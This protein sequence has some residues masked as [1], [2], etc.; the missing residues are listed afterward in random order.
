[1][2]QAP[3]P[4]HSQPVPFWRR[5]GAIALYPL[6]GAAL[7]TLILLT[8]LGMLGWLPS[9]GWIFSI[10]VYFAGYKYAFEI[11]LR[12]ANGDD[13]PPE[14]SIEAQNGAVW[15]LLGVLLALS[16][17]VKL[18]F[19]AG[20]PAAGVLALAL[21]T[22]IQPA[23][24]ALLATGDGLFTAL[25]PA[26]AVRMIDRIGA[27]YFV[28][29]AA[30]LLIQ[31]AV[32]LA[33]ASLASN[34]PGF[35]AS[36]WIDAL[37]FWGLFASFHLLGLAM[38]QYHDALGYTP[39]RHANALPTP[40]D[41]DRALLDQ[42]SIHASHGDPAGA[43]ALLR[44]ELRERPLA[45]AV[46]ERYRQLLREAGDSEAL[47][48][49]A[50]LY[51]AMLAQSKQDRL[52]LGAL[53]EALDANPHFSRLDPELRE[54]LVRRALELGQSRLAV[55]AMQALLRADPRHPDATGWALQAAQ[56]LQDRFGESTAALSVLQT[57][58]ATCRNEAGIAELDAAIARLQPVEPDA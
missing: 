47:D 5:P 10:I 23:V 46:H 6:R 54:G 13:R 33:S 19:F 45:P 53:R 17:G 7:V 52:A 30:L 34:L 36:L 50:G 42:V 1:M 2:P 56:L 4:M 39:S 57:T 55:D 43:I 49:H 29:A 3:L 31:I 40:Q 26:N 12:T 35:L 48:A 32:V 14:V 24:T 28:V 9:S 27:A 37:F 16:I 18:A 44:D 11:L 8:V 15:R 41:R 51:I 22:F 20:I 38:Y 21:F 25:N 58:R